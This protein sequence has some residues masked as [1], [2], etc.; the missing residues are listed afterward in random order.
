MIDIRFKGKN[1]S[2][3]TACEQCCGAKLL[4]AFIQLSF[5]RIK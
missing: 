3:N 1:H 5:N 4:E 2:R